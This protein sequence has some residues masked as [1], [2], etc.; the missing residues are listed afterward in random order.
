MKR[1]RMYLETRPFTLR[2]DNQALL[3]LNNSKEEKSK[4]TRWSLL[5]QEFSYTVEHVPARENTFADGLSR[6]PSEEVTTR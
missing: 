6:F 1:Y 5:L 4:Y 3:W 2:T